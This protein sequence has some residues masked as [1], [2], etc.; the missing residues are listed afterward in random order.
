[1]EYFVIV[2]LTY[3]FY[4]HIS[5][6]IS[7]TY[8]PF[9][10]YTFIPMFSMMNSLLGAKRGISA[11]VTLCITFLAANIAQA[12]IFEISALFVRLFIR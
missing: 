10:I 12:N 1:M 5:Y 4:N 2:T 6:K 11:I 7:D 9:Y 8:I 3:I